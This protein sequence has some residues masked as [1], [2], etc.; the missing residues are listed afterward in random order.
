MPLQLD[1]EA[2]SKSH[3]DSQ[4]ASNFHKFW[5]NFGVKNFTVKNDPKIKTLIIDCYNLVDLRK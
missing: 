3:E 2:T 4:I 5:S 1:L